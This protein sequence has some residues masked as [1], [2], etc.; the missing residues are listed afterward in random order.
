[1]EQMIKAK[2]GVQGRSGGN[3]QV[4][5]NAFQRNRHSGC[6]LKKSGTWTGGKRHSDLTEQIFM[7]KQN[8]F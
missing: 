1:M 7:M 2:A 5:K 4:G 6:A 3:G 8:C